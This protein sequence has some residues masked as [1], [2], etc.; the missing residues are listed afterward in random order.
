MSTEK[1]TPI[2]LARKFRHGRY[3]DVFGAVCQLQRPWESK[4]CG[5]NLRVKDW[6]DEVNRDI[7]YELFCERCKTCDPDGWRLQSQVIDAAARFGASGTGIDTEL[8]RLGH[9]S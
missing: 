9:I 3:L 1:T 6:R 8:P 4:P 5:G 7:R 2:I